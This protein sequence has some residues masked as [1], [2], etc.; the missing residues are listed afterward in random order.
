LNKNK[1]SQEDEHII[2][3][4]FS[5]KEMEKFR[6]AFDILR[7]LA[8][9]YPNEYEIYFLLGSALYQCN[10][11]KGA[12]NYLK[13]A[14]S[15]NPDHGLSSLNLF[16]ALSELN[17]WHTAL[18]ELRRFLS[19]KGRNEKEH[20]L[21]LQELREGINNFSTSERALISSLVSRFEK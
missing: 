9:K 3:A 15:L 17:K 16:H 2:D 10:D 7:P 19:I 20:L 14:V 1:I 21:L 8:E 6:E 12:V 4:F 18:N 5:L 13:K 11:F